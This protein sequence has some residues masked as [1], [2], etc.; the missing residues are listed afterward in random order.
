MCPVCNM[1]FDGPTRLYK[2]FVGKKLNGTYCSTQMFLAGLAM[3]EPEL[4]K[5]RKSRQVISKALRKKGRSHQAT[6]V[7]ARKKDGEAWC[8]RYGP[9]CPEHQPFETQDFSRR[10]AGC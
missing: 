9:L 10:P 8:P 5:A 3:S 2:H 6:Q 7:M 1:S 4:E